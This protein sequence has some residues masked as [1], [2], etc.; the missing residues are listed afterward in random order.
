MLSQ[1]TILLRSVSQV[2][3]MLVMSL[4]WDYI[5][6]SVQLTPLPKTDTETTFRCRRP[7]VN[8]CLWLAKIK[9]QNGGKTF[10]NRLI[11]FN[12]LSKTTPIF[13]ML[14]FFFYFL[15]VCYPA[16]IKFQNEFTIFK[17]LWNANLSFL[18]HN[19][20]PRECNCVGSVMVSDCIRS[21]F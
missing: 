10:E 18:Y 5:K 21:M 1:Y 11:L 4:I 8:G 7:A 20:W 15:G 17:W 9:T 13:I 14:F 3:W 16:R 19:Y 2:V 6:T 12:A